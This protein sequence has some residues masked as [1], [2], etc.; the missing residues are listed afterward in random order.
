MEEANLQEEEAEVL[1][2]GKQQKM[3]EAN[4]Q[5]QALQ[6]RN[7]QRNHNLKQSQ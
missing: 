6:L 4:L 7:M 2:I 3:E 1:Q 5:D